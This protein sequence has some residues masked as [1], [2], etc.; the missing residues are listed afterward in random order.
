MSGNTIRGLWAQVRYPLGFGRQAWKQDDMAVQVFGCGTASNPE[1]STIDGCKFFNLNLSSTTSG[2]TQVNGIYL[3]MTKAGSAAAVALKIEVSGGATA[4]DISGSIAL[5]GVATALLLGSQANLSGSGT[6]LSSTV[7]GALRV[8]SDDGGANVAD[9]V[10]GVQSRTL[11]TISQSAGTIRALQ[12]QLKVLTGVNFD[13]GVYTPV[14]GYIELVNTNTVSASGTLACFDA[15]LELGGVL[16]VT[17]QMFG[18]RLETT[19]AGSFAG[20]G[21]AAAIGLT[22]GGTAAWPIGLYMKSDAVVKGIL[23]GDSTSSPV[24]VTATGTSSMVEVN[25]KLT[26]VSGILRGILSYVEFSG[27]N[28]GVT[29]NLYA[30]RGYAKVSGTTTDAGNFTAGVQ[31]KLELSGTIGGGKHA[32]VLAQINSSAGLTGATSGTVYGLWVDGMQI[33]QTPASALNMTM[34][35]IEMPDAAARFDSAIYVYG[36]ATY[37]FDLANS[38]VGGGYG[39]LKAQAPGV[40]TGSL[41]I[42]LDGADYYIPIT[43]DPTA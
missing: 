31:G 40:V 39:S 16:T 36:G 13:T 14:Q 24:L 6:K 37:L 18:L 11:L 12:G 4:L 7:P 42:R 41:K 9:S 38:G 23:I 25:A 27:V 10:R 33:T 22:I 20:A 21:K 30:I 2:S 26:A 34:I 15:S 17:G 8:F 1:A 35:G 32:A 3:K 29:A 28:V 43:N 19:G 5:S